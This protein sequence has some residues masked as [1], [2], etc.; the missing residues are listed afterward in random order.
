MDVELIDKVL[1]TQGAAFVMLALY[2]RSLYKDRESERSERREAYKSKN[3]MLEQNNKTMLRVAEVI[4]GLI[5][6]VE[7]LKDVVQEKIKNR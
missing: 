6:T 7:R 2:T 4:D 3:E 5:A 1:A